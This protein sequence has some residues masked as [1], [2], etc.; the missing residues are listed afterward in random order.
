VAAYLIRRVIPKRLLLV[1]QVRLVRITSLVQTERAA[2]MGLY[3][4]ILS[5]QFVSGRLSVWHKRHVAPTRE[6]V[7]DLIRRDP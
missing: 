5:E 1:F 2:A 3:A 6:L 7:N 4:F